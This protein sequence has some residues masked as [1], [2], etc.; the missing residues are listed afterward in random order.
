MNSSKQADNPAADK[1]W[2]WR[3]PQ[4]LVTPRGDDFTTR[5]VGGQEATPHSYP[6][7]VALFIGEGYF[8]GGSIISDQWILTAA[9][10]ID[11]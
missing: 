2:T 3:S 8:C 10:C 1:P 9:H 11:G 5:I 4:P 6:F 7:Q